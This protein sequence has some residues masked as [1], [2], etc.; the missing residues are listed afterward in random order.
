MNKIIVSLCLALLSSVGMAETQ[1]GL[2][3]MQEVKLRNTGWLDMTADLE[4]VLTNKNGDEHR[5]KLA[6]KVLEI[7][8]D[9]DK[10]LSV[11]NSPRDVKGTAFLSFTHALD[12]DEQWLYLPAL[13]RVKRI[14][15]SNKSGPFLGSEIAFEDLSSFEL[16]KYTYTY[17]K[18]EL[19]DSIDCFV[20]ENK[21]QYEYSGYVR[22]IVWVDKLRYIP[23]KIDYYD[24]KNTLL[25]TQTFNDYQQYLDKYW[26]A[27][28]MLMK[29][30]VT[31]KSTQ[32]FWHNYKF[33]SGLTARQFDKNSLK[34]SR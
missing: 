23:M 21:P 14:S 9:G 18:D 5:R 19:L 13:K 20:I 2:E 34:R 27:D 29:N 24:R 25:K 6:M 31:G 4:M 1:T 30:Y 7:E 32:L 8:E 17:L 11:F 22:T 33:S 12:A 26:R 28:S 10:S 16:E 15:S 3:I